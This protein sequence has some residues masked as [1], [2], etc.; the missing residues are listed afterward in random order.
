MSSDQ[1]VSIA[2]DAQAAQQHGADGHQGRKQAAHGNGDADGVVE[3]GQNEVLADL[4][5]DVAAEIQEFSDAPHTFHADYRPSYRGN[6]AIDGWARCL[7]W[8]NTY[9]KA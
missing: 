7:A 9:L 4:A 8:F 5:V 1:Q 3:E 6:S 2:D